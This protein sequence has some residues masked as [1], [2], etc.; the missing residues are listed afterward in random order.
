M[1][2]VLKKSLKGLGKAVLATAALGAFLMLGAAPRAVAD[3]DYC[4]H[5]IAKADH[6][7]HEAVEH[8]GWNSAQAVRA[9]H[10]LHEAREDCWGRFHKWWDE[11]GHRWRTE[12]DWDDHDHDHERDHDH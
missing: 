4:R 11:D 10:Q 12:H 2:N 6:K 1:T 9:R 5:R 7:V 8:H 3:D